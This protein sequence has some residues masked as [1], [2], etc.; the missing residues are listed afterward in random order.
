MAVS[1]TEQFS[2]LGSEA[3]T[4]RIDTLTP[5]CNAYMTILRVQG[6]VKEYK[7]NLN[8]LLVVPF[9][10]DQAN[11]VTNEHLMLIDVVGSNS[12]FNALRRSTAANRLP[13][14]SEATDTSAAVV[15]HANFES[16]VHG[17]A[18]D[19]VNVSGDY[20]RRMKLIKER[21]GTGYGFAVLLPEYDL[22]NGASDFTVGWVW[23]GDKAAV[24]CASAGNAWVY[25]DGVTESKCNRTG[26]RYPSMR[27]NAPTNRLHQYLELCSMFKPHN[28][29]ERK[30]I[31]IKGPQDLYYAQN[32]DTLLVATQRR[33]SKL[34]S[35]SVSANAPA[36]SEKSSTRK[37]LYIAL[38]VVV[39]GLMLWIAVIAA[40]A[41]GKPKF[42]GGTTYAYLE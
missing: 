40:N 5:T 13:V 37:Y 7:R 39:T 41:A 34:R 11:E 22:N 23:Y 21:Y 6:T 9:P 20:E 1:L 27:Q 19:E 3:V 35:K 4:A 2:I 12:I 42:Y 25:N 36:P 28:R 16:F 33:P 32:T 18:W 10:N 17:T 31:H 24:P 8:Q 38:A 30:T 15:L 26:R 14:K 29:A